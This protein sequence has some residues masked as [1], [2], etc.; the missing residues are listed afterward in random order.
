MS[1]LTLVI[2]KYLQW[3]LT[4]P[5]CLVSKVTAAASPLGLWTP[6]PTTGF[7]PALWYQMWAPF[8]LWGFRF[9][10]RASGCFPVS[11]AFITT[12]GHVLCVTLVVQ[13]AW[14][15]EKDK[16]CWGNWEHTG[17]RCILDL[18][19]LSSNESA[20]KTLMWD[21]KLRNYLRKCKNC[22]KQ[23]TNNFKI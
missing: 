8:C 6:H 9:S 17:R 20:P 15:P 18:Y 11:H 19:M 2:V 21:S 4:G 13:H 1:T 10:Q 16:W 22:K 5:S 3:D 14:S 7:R 23:N 12:V